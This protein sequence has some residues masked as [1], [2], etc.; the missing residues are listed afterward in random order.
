[1][2]TRR[3]ESERTADMGRNGEMSK[4]M[5]IVE[6]TRKTRRRIKRGKSIMQKSSFGRWDTT[7]ALLG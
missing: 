7:I 2:R 3:W 6:K 1:M 5:R 4:S